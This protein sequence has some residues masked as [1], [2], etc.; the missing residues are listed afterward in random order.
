MCNPLDA[1]PSGTGSLSV[2]TPIC[3]GLER[4]EGGPN[5]DIGCGQVTALD[6]T[7]FGAAGQYCYDV[8]G[9]QG[10]GTWSLGFFS[11]DGES[12]NVSV[13]WSG[14]YNNTIQTTATCTE[15]GSGDDT[16]ITYNLANPNVAAVQTFQNDGFFQKAKVFFELPIGD[17]GQQTLY[18]F[19]LAAYPGECGAD[20]CG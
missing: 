16:S 14:T 11:T 9:Y 5:I 19:S 7:H 17:L 12:W 4:P 8:L 6:S 15:S 18:V 1:V 2:G 10:S 13:V 20:C 3:I